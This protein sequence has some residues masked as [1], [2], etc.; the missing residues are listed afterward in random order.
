M[1]DFQ[2]MVYSVCCR[3][4]TSLNCREERIRTGVMLF[5]VGNVAS[6]LDD[7]W[8]AD[9]MSSGDHGMLSGD[10]ET[11]SGD[12]AMTSGDHE[13]TSGAHGMTCGAHGTTS[14][15]DYVAD[16][17]ESVMVSDSAYHTFDGTV[18]GGGAPLDLVCGFFGPIESYSGPC[19][20]SSFYLRD[21]QT[22]FHDKYPLD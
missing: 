5:S 14:A 15:D 2:D 18:H 16:P 8:T 13:M 12:H 22:N 7:G 4:Q 11:T 3:N 1:V 10:H 17:P 9:A 19:G 6:L 20:F 21:S